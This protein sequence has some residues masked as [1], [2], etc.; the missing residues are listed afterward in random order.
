MSDYLTE[1]ESFPLNTWCPECGG[2]IKDEKA[3]MAYC[4]MHQP[5]LPMGHVGF[6]GEAGG[7]SN[8]AICDF[9]HRKETSQ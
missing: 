1:T 2:P 3:A 7:D 4:I 8:K 5:S 9:L 6:H